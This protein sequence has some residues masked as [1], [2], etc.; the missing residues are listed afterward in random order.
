MKTFSTTLLLLVVT[1]ALLLTPTAGYS[2]GALTND[3]IV[4]LVKAGLGEEVV[5]SMVNLQPAQY[6]LTPDAL[7]ALKKEGVS[8]KVIAAMLSKAP[9]PAAQP[10]PAQPA[11]FAAL[12]A[13]AADAGPKEVGVYFKKNNAWVEVMPEIINLKSG[14]VLKR[15]ATA[16]VIKGDING[17]IKGARSKNVVAAPLEFL[18]RLSEG[19]AITEYQLIRLNVNKDDR[20]FRSVTGGVFHTSGGSNR[21][22]LPFEATKLAERSFQ[23]VLPASMGAGEYGFLP[24]GA[25]NA[26]SASRKMYT[27]RIP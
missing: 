1:A 24:P 2:Q 5:L 17:N 16:G 8:D 7:I 10:A 11:N 15:I 18:I 9:S 23:V 3:S 6:E 4:K 25:D 27:F 12:F 26:N 20:E 22:E 14:G 13:A 19:V 21:D